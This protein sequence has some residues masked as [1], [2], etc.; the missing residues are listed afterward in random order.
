MRCRSCW[1][2]PQLHSWARQSPGSGFTHM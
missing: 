1:R 2:S